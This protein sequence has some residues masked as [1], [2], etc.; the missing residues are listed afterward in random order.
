V[1]LNLKNAVTNLKDLLNFRLSISSWGPLKVGTR[2]IPSP[3]WQIVDSE[4]ILL[5]GILA[6]TGFDL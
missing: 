2:A 1:A 4:I 3:S 5:S 6:D